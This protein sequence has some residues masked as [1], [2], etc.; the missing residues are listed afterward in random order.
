MIVDIFQT[1]VS[2]VGT[3]KALFIFGSG[4]LFNE[5]VCSSQVLCNIWLLQHCILPSEATSG[6][7]RIQ[8]CS[9]IP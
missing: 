4:P 3:R 1:T 6:R 5:H 8:A 7:S 2:Q 9:A